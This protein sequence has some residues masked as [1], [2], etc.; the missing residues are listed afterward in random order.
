MSNVYCTYD[1]LVSRYGEQELIDLT[2]R[3]GLGEV[4]MAS[5]D[6][7]VED[8]AAE[9]DSYLLVRYCLPLPVVPVVLRNFALDMALYKLLNLRRMGDIE[10]IQTRYKE[11]IRWLERVRDYKAEI[12]GAKAKEEQAAAPSGGRHYA[13]S[14]TSRLDWS[15]Y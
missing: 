2:D 1:D 13:R 4:R 12:A 15:G 14:C 10:D 7:A 11:A 5:I 6:E 8:A 3:E 9:I